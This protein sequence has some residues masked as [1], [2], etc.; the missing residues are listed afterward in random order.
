[1]TRFRSFK[2]IKTPRAVARA[3]RASTGKR[4]PDRR[5]AAPTTIMS[6]SGTKP[7]HEAGLSVGA[8]LRT[9]ALGTAGARAVKRPRVER[10][11]LARLS[12]GNRKTR[13]ERQPAGEVVEHAERTRRERGRASAFK[14]PTSA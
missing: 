5:A 6:L 1:M 13:L 12:W 10:E 14:P 2:A 4:P 9:M 8:F 7:P 3:D 11:Q